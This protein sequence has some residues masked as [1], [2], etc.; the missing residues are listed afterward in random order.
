MEMNVD[1]LNESIL[2]Q[3]SMSALAARAWMVALVRIRSISTHVPAWTAGREQI[4]NKVIHSRGK[5]IVKKKQESNTDIKTHFCCISI[6]TKFVWYHC[7]YIVR[8]SLLDF[9]QFINEET[10]RSDFYPSQWPF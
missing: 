8:L 2:W 4:V 9:I 6:S 3:I 5:S 1:I 7:Q 10:S